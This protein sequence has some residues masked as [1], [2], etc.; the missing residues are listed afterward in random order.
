VLVTRYC[1]GAT[2]QPS[3]L[4]SGQTVMALFQHTLA[5][6][7]RTSEALAVLRASTVGIEAWRGVRGDVSEF[8]GAILSR[9]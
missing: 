4:S 8:V 9:H 2:W 3:P 7:T 6:R 5:A 1:H